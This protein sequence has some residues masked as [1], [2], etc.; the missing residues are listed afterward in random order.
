VRA[1]TTEIIEV[2][3]TTAITVDSWCSSTQ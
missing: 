1:R 2:L 3:L